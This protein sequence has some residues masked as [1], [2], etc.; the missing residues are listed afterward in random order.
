VAAA[1]RKA[2]QAMERDRKAQ[3]K[4]GPVVGTLGPVAAASSAGRGEKPT[5]SK[6]KAKPEK[7]FTALAPAP[8]Q[9]AP[10]AK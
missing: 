2:A 6:A 1:E 9:T 8:K 10:A 4:N 5:R 3:A 7:P